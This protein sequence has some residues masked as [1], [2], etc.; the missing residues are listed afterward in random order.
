VVSFVVE[1][2]QFINVAHDHAQID[3]GVGGGTRGTLAQEIIHGVVIIYAGGDVV[4]SIDTMD[5]GEK[6]VADGLGDAYF[7]L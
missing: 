3:F 5:V 7:V 6:D 1:H 2:Q 4:A